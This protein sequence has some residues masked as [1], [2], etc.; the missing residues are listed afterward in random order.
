MPNPNKACQYLAAVFPYVMR[1]MARRHVVLPQDITDLLPKNRLLSEVNISATSKTWE[2]GSEMSSDRETM[3][4][5][6]NG[7]LLVSSKAVV[8]YT[9]QSTAQNPTSCCSG[10][11]NKN[12]LFLPRGLLPVLCFGVAY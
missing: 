3:V 10:R 12:T 1:F 9:M 7:V 5:R 4:C 11:P 2:E 8:G 6:Q